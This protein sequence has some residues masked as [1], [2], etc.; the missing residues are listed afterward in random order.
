M[1][2]P[3]EQGYISHNH[4][5]PAFLEKYEPQ[6]EDDGFELLMSASDLLRGRGGLDFLLHHYDVYKEKCQLKSKS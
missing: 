3:F 5:N 4:I 2:N 6:E 1:P